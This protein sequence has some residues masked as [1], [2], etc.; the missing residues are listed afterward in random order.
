[1]VFRYLLKNNKDP[2]ITVKI[3]TTKTAVIIADEFEKTFAAGAEGE[4]RDEGTK[5]KEGV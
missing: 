2:I 3:A 4:G 1:M 5:G